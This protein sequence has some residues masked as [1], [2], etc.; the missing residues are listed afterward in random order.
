MAQPG[1]GKQLDFVRLSAAPGLTRQQCLAQLAA[2]DVPEMDPSRITE[3]QPPGNRQLTDL[4]NATE[5]GDPHSH[6]ATGTILPSSPQQKVP[7]VADFEA[8]RRSR[9]LTMAG[10]SR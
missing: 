2:C 7:T 10:I 9:R 5:C 1:F 8:G 3:H 6:L 4:L